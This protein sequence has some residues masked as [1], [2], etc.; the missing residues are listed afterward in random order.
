MAKR[1]ITKI[2]DIFSVELDNGNKKF[3]Q[4][5]ANDL[6]QLNSDVIR[7]Y[8]QEYL[9]DQVPDFKELLSGEIDFHTH[10]PINIGVKQGL[11]NPEGNYAVYPNINSVLFRGTND[12]GHGP[13][14]PQVFIS[15]DWYVWK[16]ND[17]NFKNV[18]KLNGENRNAEIGAVIPP[19]MVVERIRT[20]K[21]NFVYPDFQ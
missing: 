5:I 21:F 14:K 8:K 11:F 15:E 16:I 10:T 17:K 9:K 3:F 12:A 2:G 13:G 19:L 6:T 20:G 7:S 1:V 4:Y 18:G